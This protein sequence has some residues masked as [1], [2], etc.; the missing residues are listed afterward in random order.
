MCIRNRVAISSYP[1]G[2]LQCN[3][4]TSEGDVM[5]ALSYENIFSEQPEFHVGS[6]AVK[7]KRTPQAGLIFNSGSFHVM[8][9]NRPPNNSNFGKTD[10]LLRYTAQIN[11][12]LI[13]NIE[14]F[15]GFIYFFIISEP[16]PLI[17][18]PYCWNT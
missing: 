7:W 14:M 15:E 13:L 17:H 2:H 6:H 4:I 16:P 18:M 5:L 8:S 12:L 3:G 11:V 10:P 1:I 9:G